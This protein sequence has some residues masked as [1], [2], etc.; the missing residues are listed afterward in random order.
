M[1]RARLIYF[2]VFAV[3]IA[4]ALLPAL[5]FFPGGP[6][7]GADRARARFARRRRAEC[8]GSRLWLLDEP[9]GAGRAE[10]VSPAVLDTGSNGSCTPPWDLKGLHESCLLQAESPGSSAFAR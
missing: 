7:D 1:S 2:A 6:H 8:A 9:F 5:Q 4:T 3:L 10:S